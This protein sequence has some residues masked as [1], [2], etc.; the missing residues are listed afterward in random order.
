MY[1]TGPD[2]ADLL[3]QGDDLDVI[4]LAQQHLPVVTAQVRA[5]TRGRGFDPLTN[6]PADDVALVIVSTTARHVTNPQNLRSET[7]GPFA[8]A[9]QIVNGWTLPELAVLHRYRR[10]AQ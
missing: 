5:Y 7:T 9:Y 3:G 8:V 4:T 2:V 10:R 1:P 6:E